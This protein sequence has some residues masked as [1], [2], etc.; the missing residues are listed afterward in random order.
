MNDSILVSVITP[1]FNAARFMVEMVESVRNQD[2]PNIEHIVID[3][4]SV[5]GTQQILARYS[6]LIWISEIDRGQSHALNKGFQRAKGEIIGW[7]NAD[8]LYRPEAVSRAVEFLQKNPDVDFVYSDCAEIDENDTFVRLIRGYPVKGFQDIVF[9]QPI[10]QPTVF[11]RKRVLEKLMGVDESL[12]FVMDWEFWLRASFHY[13]FR[14]LSGAPLASFRKYPGTKSHDV[15]REFNNEWIAVL[16]RWMENTQ[17]PVFYVSLF[18]KGIRYQ[19]ALLYVA[20][21]LREA[22]NKER[23]VAIKNLFYAVRE[24]PSISTVR[25]FIYLMFV[26][27][28]GGEKRQP[29]ISERSINILYVQSGRGIGG[30]KISLLHIIRS[31]GRE[32]INVHLALS[33]PADDIFSEMIGLKVASIQTLYLP[34][35]YKNSSS[36]FSDHLMTLLARLRRGWYIIPVLQLIYIILKNKIDL[37][38]SNSSASPVGAFAAWLTRRPHVWYIREP[39]GFGTEFPLVFGDRVSARLMQKL[40]S[41][42]I[43]ISAYTAEIFVKHG[44][45]LVMIL[46]GINVNEFE[47]SSEREDVLRKKL[48]VNANTVIGMIGSLRANWKEHSLFLKA[49]ALVLEKRPDIGIVVFGGTSDLDITDYTRSLAQLARSLSLT[50]HIIWADHVDDIP[51]IVNSFDI[52]VHPVSKEGSGRAIMEAMAAGKPVIAIKSGGV[53]E[54]IQHEQTGLLVKPGDPP[55][56]AEAILRLMNDPEMRQRIGQQAKLYAHNHFSHERTAS[57][58]FQ[59]YQEVLA[60]L[61][62]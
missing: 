50:N 30:A 27:L 16:K 60:K 39:I 22:Q 29:D 17:G 42:I 12:H 7:L 6:E 23:L 5:D 56:L 36:R 10:P 1:C 37:V 51:A 54:L 20:D 8:D 43:C 33:A 40:S 38:H 13:Q 9:R 59:I 57:Q 21:V 62:Q 31:L 15:P 19:R 52:L 46:N 11:F 4:S 2:Y 32:K 25:I 34:V 49:M 53:Q 24:F 47:F 28:M 35:W 44:I 55:A 26:I 18:E 58:V 14:Y 41:Q 61:D 3:G 45:Q 48:G